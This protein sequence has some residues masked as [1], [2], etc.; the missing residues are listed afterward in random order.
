MTRKERI[1][2]FLQKLPDDVSYDRV[3]YHVGVM[4]A[5]EEALVESERGEGIE[6]EELFRRLLRENE[7]NH[8]NLA[9]A[10]RKAIGANK[11]KD[12]SRQTNSRRK[13]RQKS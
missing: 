12:S 7:K 13:V 8:I 2:N 5:I 3:L 6:H 9:A 1:L 4:K 10:R 11:S